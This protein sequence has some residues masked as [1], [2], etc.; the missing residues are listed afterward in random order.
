MARLARMPD[1]AVKALANAV[2][3][4]AREA[5]QAVI[6]GLG[7]RFVI[8]TPWIA[9]GIRVAPARPSRSGRVNAVVFSKDEFMAAQET[10]GPRD[11]RGKASAVP[12]GA[13]P[14]PTSITRP[15]KFPGRLKNAFPATINGATGIWQRSGRPRIATKGRYVGKKRQPI[16]LMYLLDQEVD[17]KP[18]FEMRETVMGVVR[19]RFAPNAL[20]AIAAELPR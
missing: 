16:R 8:R 4:T 17:L 11:T 3:A 5:Q 2:T 14:R 12:V 13:R 18:R 6:Q 10:G 15:S 7:D 9:K 1:I 20:A 19:D